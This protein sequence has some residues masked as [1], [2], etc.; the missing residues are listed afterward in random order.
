MLGF[1]KT[2]IPVDSAHPSSTT[3]GHTSIYYA[4][5]EYTYLDKNLVVPLK[6]R[7]VCTFC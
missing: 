1:G 4:C 3:D 7:L 5:K 6:M 2:I